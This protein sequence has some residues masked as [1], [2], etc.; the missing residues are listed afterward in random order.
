MKRKIMALSIAASLIAGPASAA[1]AA[2]LPA[3]GACTLWYSQPASNPITEGLP[4]GN[5]RLGALV[6]GQVEHERIVLNEDSLW[7]GDDNPG[8]DYKDMGA[9]QMLGELLLSFEPGAAQPGAAS[10]GPQA[11]PA[12]ENYR[13]ELELST[14]M[15]RTTFTRDG[16]RHRREMFASYPAQVLVLRWSADRPGAI[17]GTVE[18]KGAHEEST[19]AQ[20]S[21]LSFRGALSNGMR[22]ETLA[23]VVAEGGAVSARD[24]RLELKGCDAATILIAGGTD[25]AMDHARHYRGEDPHARLAAQLDSASR[26]PYE[27][28]KAAHV[29]DF[30]AIFGRVALDLGCSSEAQ[31]AL[32]S[33]ER[34]VQAAKS[35]DPELESLLFQY[36]RYLLISC[37]RRAPSG[38]GLPANLQGLWNDSNSP[39]WHADYHANINVQMNY[40]PAE[41]A[42]IAE[43]HLPFFDLIRSQLPAWR[44]ATAA[45]PEF[46]TP[47]GAMTSRGWAIR[48]SHNIS[49]GMGWNWDKT[50]NAWY[51]QHLWEYFAF[52]QDTKYLREVAYP[53]L[54]ETTQFWEDHLKALP[55]GRLVVPNAWS[56]EH[57]PVEDGVSYSQQIVWDLF[58]NYV[59]AAQVLGLDKDYSA[60]IQTMRGRLV[61]PQIGKWG[62]LQEWMSDRDDPN[63]HHRHTSH[64]FGVFPGREISVAKTPELARAALVSLDAR[65]IDEGSDVREW[66]FAW[67]TSLYARLHEG[68]K[69]HNMVQQLF[70]NRNSCLNLFGLHP[71]MQMDGNFGVTAGIAEMLLQSHE[72]SISL[73][74]ALPPAWP[75]GSVRGLRARGGFE[76]DEAWQAGKL[77]SATIRRASASVGASGAASRVQVLGGGHSVALQLKP[78]QSVRLSSSLA[79]LRERQGSR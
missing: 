28:L 53:I 71:P 41:V 78:G 37:S 26:Q 52:G 57:G 79:P 51:C 34:K 62:Q 7:T 4:V 77:S 75:E 42:N 27:A 5:G 23:R 74:P 49:G 2:P 70:S 43:A 61:G 68:E 36:G 17:S 31:R 48:T 6:L 44:Q 1:T 38:Q 30:Q 8:G 13:R 19:S 9:Y 15:A 35:V 63:D 33:D 16:A 21:T 46:K 69:A 54:K 24:G 18:L 67:R 47:G 64:L 60:R 3:P 58:T 12:A 72:D 59:Q 65:G 73:L 56:P 66:S 45:S 22:Y 40:W 29:R 39:P 50:A 76:V 55:D 25:Y 20:G 11:P 32:S 10:P 14:A